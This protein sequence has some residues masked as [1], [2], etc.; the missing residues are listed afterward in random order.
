MDVKLIWLCGLD[1]HH[2]ANPGQPPVQNWQHWVQPVCRIH[3]MCHWPLG[4]TTCRLDPVL[5]AAQ[6]VGPGHIQPVSWTPYVT[7]SACFSFHTMGRAMCTAKLRAAMCSWST[8][9]D[10]VLD[11]AK[12]V[13]SV[14]CMQHPRPT[15]CHIWI[16]ACMNARSSP[17]ATYWPSVLC[18]S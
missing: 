6:R 18:F 4:P 12:E 8:G 1:E 16:W 14:G 10:L 15:S 5:Q 9:L 2:W 13:Q 11:M 17:H 3:I 7:W